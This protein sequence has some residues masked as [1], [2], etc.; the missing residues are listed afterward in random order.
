MA[1]SAR[2]Y[3]RGN[4]VQ[5][6]EWLLSK[7]V[8]AT[9]PAGPD[10]WISGDCHTGNLGPVA[11][12]EAHI[13]IQI[14]DFDQTVIGNP[15]H[16]L[17][18]LGLSLAMAAR[19]S[20]LSEVTTAL[21]LEETIDGYLSGLTCH[22]PRVDPNDIEPIRSVMRDAKNRQ[23][24]HLAEEGVEDVRPTIPPGPKFWKLA[25]K[26]NE[27]LQRLFD[28]HGLHQ[29]IQTLHMWQKGSIR[30]VF[31]FITVIFQLHHH[32]Q[33][34][35]APRRFEDLLALYPCHHRQFPSFT[36]HAFNRTAHPQGG[37]LAGNSLSLLAED[38]DQL[39]RLIAHNPKQKSIER[40][41]QQLDAIGR[42]V[43]ERYSISANECLYFLEVERTDAFRFPA[44]A[45]GRWMQGGKEPPALR[46][47]S[48]SSKLNS[49]SAHLSRR[50]YG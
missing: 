1:A 27:E 25:S 18:R 9:I 42:L 48:R 26:E 23:W 2:A 49:R 28:E 34:L 21:M 3:V 19:S 33:Y 41:T 30:Y 4:T 24:R 15:A 7:S 29:L 14:R 46:K 5:F 17:L 50:A 47:E 12:V 10:I 11:D 32:A 35:R 36:C 43:R 20:D 22:S 31:V 44:N 8:Q 38:E 37:A 39:V 13:D 16:D 45:L 40:K 6:Y